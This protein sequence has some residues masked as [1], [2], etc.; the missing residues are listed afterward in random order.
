MQQFRN[1]NPVNIP[2][3]FERSASL[4]NENNNKQNNTK[5]K[6][7]RINIIRNKAIKK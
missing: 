1:G 3:S 5:Q 6:A 4:K 2:D 7:T